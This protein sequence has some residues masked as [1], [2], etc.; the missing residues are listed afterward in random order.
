M[1]KWICLFLILSLL[2]PLFGCAQPTD[3]FE[4]PISFYY[5]RKDV[6]FSTTDG[7]ISA[8]IR[9]AGN[10]D[11]ISLLALYFRG[12]ENSQLQR[13]FPE[14]TALKSIQIDGNHVFITLSDVFSTLTELD[15]SIACACLTRTVCEMT[16]TTQLTVRTENGL[17]DGN[18]TI[19]MSLKNVVLLDDSDLIIDND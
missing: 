17:L 11:Y 8:D 15:L 18:K 4:N 14:G 2:L 12:P 9:E 16:G 13:T 3:G 19:Q 5:R 1:K 6:S 7:V 10:M